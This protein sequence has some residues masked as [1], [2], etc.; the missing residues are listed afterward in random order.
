M[1][2][3]TGRRQVLGIVMAKCKGDSHRQ[4]LQALAWR[5]VRQAGQEPMWYNWA[6]NVSQ[7]EQPDEIS[8]EMVAEVGCSSEVWCALVAAVRNVLC[9]RCYSWRGRGSLGLHIGHGVALGSHVRAWCDVVLCE[10]PVPWPILGNC[11]EGTREPV[12]LVI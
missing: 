4:L 7:L 3:G 1:G 10:W 9:P 2:R 5:K 11:L 6:A 8:E 12:L